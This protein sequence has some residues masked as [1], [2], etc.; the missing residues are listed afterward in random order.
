MIWT[1]L[2]TDDSALNKEDM[3]GIGQ[4]HLT[5]ITFKEKVK[6]ISRFLEFTPM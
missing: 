6:Q 1:R 2:E 4:K 3:Q 5:E